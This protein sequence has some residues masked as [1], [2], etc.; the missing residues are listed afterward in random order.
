MNLNRRIAV[1]LIA[2][3]GMVVLVVGL[4]RSSPPGVRAASM[5]EAP[6]APVVEDSESE[7]AGVVEIEETITVIEPAA[8]YPGDRPGG[9]QV[10]HEFIVSGDSP[11]A[12]GAKPLPR[13]W[14]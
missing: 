5:L 8:T 13:R 4:S 14:E 9:A 1:L 11:A 3:M 2:W 10:T 6:R 12:G 7:A